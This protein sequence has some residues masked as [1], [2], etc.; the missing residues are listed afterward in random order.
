MKA[1][2]AVKQL[3][4]LIEKYGDKDLT[5]SFDGELHEIYEDSNIIPIYYDE[6]TNMI[7]ENPKKND[8]NFFQINRLT[9]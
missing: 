7:D 3:Q 4:S 8:V 9:L 5:Y 2:I 6:D 1:S